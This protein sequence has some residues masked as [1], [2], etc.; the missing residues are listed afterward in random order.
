[1]YFWIMQ[2]IWHGDE[3]TY[4]QAISEA[5]WLDGIFQEEAAFKDHAWKEAKPC[6]EDWELGGKWAL[7][8]SLLK[9]I[10]NEDMANNI[11]CFREVRMGGE[12]FEGPSMSQIQ[13]AGYKGKKE[14]KLGIHKAERDI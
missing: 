11:R 5:M 14:W 4:V 13:I 12:D 2:E 7:C 9:G 3:V 1:M 8:W 10:L 6:K